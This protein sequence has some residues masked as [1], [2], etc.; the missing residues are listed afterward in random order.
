MTARRAYL[1]LAAGAV[2][3]VAVALTA[4]YDWGSLVYDAG[5]LPLTAVA[6]YAAVRGP[7]TG[8]RRP[9]VLLAVA[10]T[11]WLLGDLS[12]DV[13]YYLFHSDPDTGVFDVFWMSAYPALLAG[14]VLMA[15]WRAP[16]QLRAAVLDGLTLTTAAAL[17]CWQLL[18]VPQLHGK[19]HT[20]A[21]VV[22]AIYPLLDV[23]LLAGVLLLV[24]S[25]GPRRAPTHLLITSVVL[26]LVSDLGY[27]LNPYLIPDS[28]GY[29][30]TGLMMFGNAMMVTVAL[31]PGRDELTTP[32]RRQ[33]RLHP[34]RVL[35]LGVGLLTAPAMALLPAGVPAGERVLLLVATVMIS[36]FTLARFTNAVREQERTHEQ[37]AYHAAHDPLTGLVNRR[38]LT[39]RLAQLLAEPGGEAVLLYVDLDGFKE[40]NDE[41]GHEAGD[42][43]LLEVARR[44]TATVRDTDVVARLGGDEFAV[45]CPGPVA[46]AAAVDLADRILRTLAAPVPDRSREYHVGAS[47]G[48]AAGSAA[49]LTAR[50]DIPPAQRLLSAAD[51]AMYDA[52]RRGRGGWVVAGEAAERAPAA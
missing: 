3:G 37:L 24:F 21:V 33:S 6:W 47:I 20:V 40:V 30:V 11:C 1:F 35:F 45:L 19:A 48:I 5:Y 9:W 7:R 8:S 15:R 10:Q 41:A 12:G 14:L 18:I 17:A 36:G 32:A 52:K 46:E 38:T 43:V 23:F 39:D 25:P 27:S 4:M 29:R 22:N 28:I 42:L 44:L 50:D 34:A 16:G 49:S 13:G 26:I 51:H 2:A 31:H